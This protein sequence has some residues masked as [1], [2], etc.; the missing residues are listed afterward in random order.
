MY[1]IVDTTGARGARLI[2]LFLL[3][4][5]TVCVFF[6]G[7]GGGGKGGIL[8]AEN[9]GTEWKREGG[10]CGEGGGGGILNIF[11][12]SVNDI[13]YLINQTF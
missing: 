5:Q 13:L 1:Y 9:K 12:V 6:K 8:L 3:C 10:G 2:L 11:F 7:E 4:R